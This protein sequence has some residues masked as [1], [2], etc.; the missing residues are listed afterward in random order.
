MLENDLLLQAFLA[1]GYD[2]LGQEGRDAFERFLDYPDDLLW[3]IVTGQQQT[4]D[5]GIAALVPL[6][7]AAASAAHSS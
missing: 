7:R 6:L 5:S 1:N 3:Q 2:A 4:T